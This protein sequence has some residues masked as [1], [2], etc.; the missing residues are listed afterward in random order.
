MPGPTSPSCSTP[1]DRR[2][3]QVASP[4]CTKVPASDKGACVPSKTRSRPLAVVVLAAGKGKRLKSKLPKVLHSVCGRPALWHVLQAARKVRPNRLIIVVSH[5]RDEVE[6]AVR[7][8]NV[9]P[10]PAFVDQGEPLGT[11]HAVL[12]AE[13]AVGNA[14]EVVVVP[15]DNPLITGDM[16]AA[17]LRTHRRRKATATVQTAELPDP[18][19]YGRVIRDGAEFIRIA[20]ERDATTAERRIREISTCV[21]AFSRPAL[22][23]VL[24]TVGTDN[25]QH[26]YYLPDVIGILVDKGE[27]V[28]AEPA[29]FD[30]T[31]S[32]DINTRAGLADIAAAMRRRINAAHMENGVTMIDPAQTYIDIDVKI[33]PD[34][35]IYPLTFLE[36]STG[37]GAD[38]VI[39]PSVGMLD[40]TVGDG[41]EVWFSVVLG[42]RLG[43]S[44]S[45]G[46]FAR[47]RPGTVLKDGAKAGGF[48]DIKASVIGE[49]SKVPHLSYVGD[50]TIGRNVNV[51]AGTVTVNFDGYEKHRTI[52]EDEARIGSDNMLVAPIR[53]GKGAV[54]GAG[55]VLTENVP[56]GALAVERGE[57]QNIRGYR[58]RKDAE[59]A[60]KGAG[61]VK[62]AKRK[63]KPNGG[64]R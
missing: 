38:C 5:G 62:A 53:I 46:P 15:G 61:K 25:V 50:T 51:G 54:T 7:S 41:S 11:G 57:Q 45:V 4:A 64:A 28:A 43:K 35:V 37:I 29:D 60:A 33:G 3:C 32:I 63:G 31:P 42:S 10:A 24:P 6:E 44:V 34:T 23:Q 52:I 8:W 47:L 39:G 1:S 48:V 27:P 58:K 18:K 59:R 55:S 56:A 36:G 16:L 14:A 22:F 19:G 17:I 2:S 49:G 40:T 9:R 30:G 21:Y 26:E 20:E 12:V 13:R